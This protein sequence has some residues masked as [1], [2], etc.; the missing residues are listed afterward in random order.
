MKHNDLAAAAAFLQ[1]AAAQIDLPIEPE[2]LAGVVADWVRIAVIAE[3][4]TLFPLDQSVEAAP[5]FQ[6]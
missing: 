2:H 4:V 3:F 5:V 6:P 1:A